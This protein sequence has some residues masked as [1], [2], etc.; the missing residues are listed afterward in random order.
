[1]LALND[2]ASRACI[3]DMP[4]CPCCGSGL[5]ETAFHALCE[6]VHPFWS[7]VEEWTARIGPSEL[8]LLDIGYALDNINPLFQGEKRVVFLMILAVA[9]MV[10]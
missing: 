1:M 2:W 3:A 9:R 5:E 10:I 8:V 7:H 4:D 6:W